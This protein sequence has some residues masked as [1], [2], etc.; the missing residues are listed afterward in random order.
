[1]IGRGLIVAALVVYLL[2][3]L[4]CM[5]T[6]PGEPSAD[7]LSA[8]NGSRANSLAPAE[9]LAK[10][11]LR[12]AGMQIQRI[13]WIDEYKKSLDEIAKVGG[14]SVLL[15]VDARMENGSSSLIYLDMR[16]TPTPQQLG[17]LITHAKN[18]KLRVILMP[19]VLLDKPRSMTEWRGTINPDD[20]SAWWESYR[21]L[22]Y[23][24]C[25]IAQGY[26]VDVLV[27]GSELV[28][29][30]TK[31]DEWRKTIAMVRKYY[32]GMLTYSAN[33]DHYKDIPFWDQLDLI[34][35]NSY[36]KL[37]DDQNVT[38]EE[39]QRRWTPIQQ[40]LL[41]F[42][43]KTRKPLLFLEVGWCS[44]R[45]AASEPW[46]Y[47][48]ESEP[49]D[50]DLQRRL[51]EGFFKTWYGRPELGGLMIWEWTPGDGGPKNRGYTPEGKPAEKLLKDWLAKDRWN[52]N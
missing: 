4:G 47:T 32:K 45:N 30:E 10:L 37:G 49:I 34:G 46:D 13:D 21:S 29:T 8:S 25:W 41:D 6:A 50:L 23:H 36:Y 33:W 28:S 7:S 9:H 11:P 5:L 1:M 42:V 20:W 19:I 16:L 52:V 38:V 15:V 12:G 18:L 24:Y 27:V 2:V 3:A 40:R 35:M 51:Y 31:T 14:D 22:L 48:Q 17:D 44:L 26:G 39:I 43:H